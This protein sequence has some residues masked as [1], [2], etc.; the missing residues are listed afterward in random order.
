MCELCEIPRRR[1]LF[2]RFTMFTMSTMLKQSTM[3]TQS[4]MCGPRAGT[5]WNPTPSTTLSMIRIRD[6]TARSRAGTRR[7]NHDS[8]RSRFD[9]LR[10]ERRCK[11]EEPLLSLPFSPRR[12][13]PCRYRECR[14]RSPVA[15]AHPVASSGRATVECGHSSRHHEPTVQAVDL[16][17]S[18]GVGVA[19]RECTIRTTTRTE[20]RT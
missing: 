8:T 18:S 20:A 9:T 5:I 3:S 10:D 6:V 14:L 4:T 1:E 13:K 12:Q 15:T 19:S 11:R 2:I 7:R 16:V 17:A